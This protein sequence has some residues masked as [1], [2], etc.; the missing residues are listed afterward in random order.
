MTS[1][2]RYFGTSSSRYC[3]KKDTNPRVQF[4]GSTILTLPFSAFSF[5]RVTR[6]IL[7]L[8]LLPLSL[9]AQAQVLLHGVVRDAES[10]VTLAAAHVVIEGTNQGTITNGEGRFEIVAP[11]V[12]TTLRVRYIG[13]R[14]QQVTVGLDDPRTIDVA[15]EPIVYA[16][17]EIF[18]AGDDFAENVMRKVIAQKKAWRAHLDTYQARGYTRL[19]LENASRITLIS[20]A[21]FDT[22]WDR[23]RGVR[24]VLRSRRETADFYRR[25]HLEPAGHLPDLY[26]DVIDIQGL[27]F[28]GP[29]HPD[30]LDHYAFTL[31]DRRA[32]DDQAVYDIYIAPK[33]GLDATFIGR[34]SVLDEAYTLLEVDVRP[35]RHV[36]FPPPV[37]AWDVFYRQQFTPVADT[38]W[39]PVDLRLEGTI[40]V[41]PDDLGYQAAS[42]RQVS[43]VADYH[44]NRPV[45]DSLFAHAQRLVVN[46]LS[47][48]RDHLFLLGR[49]IVSLTPR[50]AE[51]LEVLRQEEWTLERAF[52]PRDKSRAFAAFEARRNEVDGPQFA[53]PVILGY[54][55]WFRF[56]RVD[57]YFF[58]I[59]R[60]LPL[61]PNLEVEVRAAQ[62]SGLDRIRFLGRG[63]YRQ[64][65]RLT[66]T[67]RYVRDTSPRNASSIFPLALPSLASLLGQGDYFDYYWNERG[68]L[69]VGYAFPRFR[70]TLGGMLENHQSVERERMHPWPFRATFRPNPAIEDGILHAVT[71]SVAIGDGYAPFRFDPLRRAELRVEHSSDALG[72]DFGYTRYDALLDGYLPTFYRSRPH[73]NGLAVRVYGGTHQGTLPGQR[74][75]V[76]D[77]SLGAFGTFGAL[78]ALR[79][80]PYEGEQYLGLF[81]EHDFRTVPFEALGLRGLVERNMGVRL[82][83]GHGRTWID[84]DRLAA[85]TFT[86]RYQTAF[87]HEVGLALTNVLGLP[88]RLDFTYRLDQPGFYVGFGLS[89]LF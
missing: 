66:V 6:T 54:E 5:V 45:P 75:G 13:Y 34:L 4:V 84:A 50:E 55:P 21:V 36:V 7:L 25:L 49:N 41:D 10:D 81:W 63:T 38:F 73:P 69:T 30:A 20:E 14:T 83:G 22:Y 72:G 70:V 24:D 62:T 64:G 76:V 19:T 42:L 60:T 78:R 26:D 89:R 86:P 65:T 18:V 68:S 43:Q 35:A 77:G 80:Q 51:A 52:P 44:P 79:G 67:G 11:S 47:V 61:S 58:G 85:L 82:Y 29:T 1:S 27:R 9:T 46:S 15:L 33:T 3:N 56:N 88:L 17:G 39:L 71:V 40:R 8:L 48:F 16:L 31:A 28:I 87:H 59:G 32:I 37:K 23:T 57:G 12:P 74:F 53:W 2:A